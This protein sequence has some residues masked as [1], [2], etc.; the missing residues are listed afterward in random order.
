MTTIDFSWAEAPETVIPPV[1]RPGGPLSNLVA[2]LRAVLDGM[3]IQVSANHHDALNRPLRRD[4]G[5]E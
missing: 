3:F 2:E 4:L 5:L 1:A